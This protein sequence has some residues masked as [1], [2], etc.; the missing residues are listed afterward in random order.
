M[1]GSCLPGQFCPN[2]FLVYDLNVAALFAEPSN[3][4]QAQAATINQEQF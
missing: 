2:L 4:H 3:C 1:P